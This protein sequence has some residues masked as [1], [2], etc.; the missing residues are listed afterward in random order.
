LSNSYETALDF[1]SQSEK[2]LADQPGRYLLYVNKWLD[3][4]YSVLPKSNRLLIFW[5]VKNNL[6]NVIQIYDAP[7][8]VSQN[9][10]LQMPDNCT[11]SG[12]NTKILSDES[13][14]LASETCGDTKT[15]VV[16]VNLNDGSVKVV[17]MDSFISW[18]SEDQNTFVLTD[19]SKA[20][21]AY[22]V[23]T[24]KITNLPV[25]PRF[26]LS[27][28]SGLTDLTVASSKLTLAKDRYLYGFGGSTTAP[29]MYQVDLSNGTSTPVCESAIGK[30]IFLGQLP[31][32]KIFLFT[33][34]S[35]LKTYRFYQI[36]SPTDCARINEFPSEYPNVPKITA[37]NI[38]FGLLLGNPLVATSNI[39]SPEAVFVPIDGRPPLKF[40]P[41]AKGNWDLEVST[42]RN[43]IILRGPDANNVLRIFSF[44]L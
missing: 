7:S 39:Q 15:N 36:K 20:N 16:R 35:T 22:D 28:N 34:D 5:N 26:G 1:L 14:V 42:D 21:V 18:M 13:G 11:L 40:N 6:N 3:S 32:Q 8:K 31:D 12:Y 19:S 23:R 27:V 44:A 2:C 24:G 10:K 17:G 38:G 29:T 33:Y 41:D 30:K 37:T 25:D 4:G 9:L 43:R